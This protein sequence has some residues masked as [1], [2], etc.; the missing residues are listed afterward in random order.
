MRL[1]AV[2]ILMLCCLPALAGQCQLSTDS[3][4]QDAALNGPQRAIAIAGGKVAITIRCQDLA[5]EAVLQF[6]A[7]ALH[8]PKLQRAGIAIEAEPNHRLAYPIPKGSSS[9]VFTVES[10]LPRPLSFQLSDRRHY[11]QANIRHN[12]MMF[13]YLGVALALSFY[14]LLLWLR[15]GEWQFG[16]YSAYTLATAWF[17]ATQEGIPLLLA[18]QGYWLVPSL[19]LAG[20]TVFTGT[21]FFAQFLALPRHHPHFCR[22][23]VQLPALLVLLFSLATLAFNNIHSFLDTLMGLLTIWLQLSLMGLALLR[24][25]KG[26][27]D[28]VW[29]AVALALL[30]AGILTRRQTENG[31]DFIAYYGLIIAALLEAM[32]L[33]Y[34]VARRLRI[35]KQEHRQAL[36]MALTDPL[37][38]ILNRQGWQKAV[39]GQSCIAPEQWQAVYFIDLN[40]FKAVNDQHGHLGG[41][42]A[43]VTVAN[44]TQRL[45]GREATLGRYA[46]DEFVVYSRGQREQLTE[47]TQRLRRQLAAVMVPGHPNFKVSATVG[48][49]YQQGPCSLEE[50]LAAADSSMYALKAGAD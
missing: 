21:L 3:D 10:D 47:L 1:L 49:H 12:A 26:D 28:G 45:L 8:Q 14:N 29:T 9:A 6:R 19:P 38:G 25:I 20:L 44:V 41:D 27:R 11:R 39:A 31:G 36:H 16:L 35:I 43:L 50:L 7:L 24:A 23:L 30:L 13:G 32:L 4:S 33:A 22:W 34:M 5:T 42:K 18:G 46:G 2:L 40:A 48:V 37:T 17:F 15:M